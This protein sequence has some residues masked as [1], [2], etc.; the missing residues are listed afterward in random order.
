VRHAIIEKLSRIIFQPAE[1]EERVVYLLVEI[2][3]LIEHADLN[4]DQFV[5][6]RFFCNWAV[7]TKLTRGEG[8]KIVA[9]LNDLFEARLQGRLMGDEQRQKLSD[10]F[11]FETFRRELLDFLRSQGLVA[12]GDGNPARL[13]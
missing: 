10:V 1:T 4:E 2:R 6:L 8:A 9:L 12:L 5:T 3:K 7:H 11:S 13:G